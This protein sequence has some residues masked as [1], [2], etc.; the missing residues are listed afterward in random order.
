V[1]DPVTTAVKPAYFVVQ[2][3]NLPIPWFVLLQVECRNCRINIAF[4]KFI[5]GTLFLNLQQKGK[6]TKYI[7]DPE[8]LLVSSQQVAYW[9]IS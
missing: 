7:Y 2:I 6:K 3:V 8:G 9:F 1:P 4:L 5:L